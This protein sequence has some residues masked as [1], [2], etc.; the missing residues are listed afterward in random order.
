M[1]EQ[2]KG[3]GVILVVDDAPATV[4]VLERNLSGAGYRVLTAGD[5]EAAL[6]VL[7]VTPV[8]VVVTDLKMPRVTGMEVVRFV[9]ERLP[10][11][12]VMMITGYA[13]I[14]GAVEAVKSG[15]EEYLAKPFTDEELF[16]AVARVFAK[17]NLRRSTRLRT[18]R[19]PLAPEGLL[20]ESPAM[21]TVLE[22][23]SAAVRSPAPLLLTGE[24]GTGKTLAAR[25]VHFA[26]PTRRGPLVSVNCAGTPPERLAS[27]L[28]AQ[29]AN[30][31]ARGLLD[32]ARG[33]TLLLEEVSFLPAAIQEGILET[34]AAIQISEPGPAPVIR[35]IGTSRLGL[36]E[37]PASGSP[38]QSL[39]AGFEARRVELPPLRQRDGDVLLLARHLTSRFSAER[40]W[41]PPALQAEAREVLPAYRWPGNVRELEL[42]LERAVS[43]A[44]EHGEISAAILGALIS[45]REAPAADPLRPLSEVEA[46]HVQQVVAA[47]QGNKTRAAQVLGIDRKTLREKLRSLIPS[48]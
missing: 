27:E 24:T 22:V 34:L 4:E 35:L 46:E 2:P 16:G 45:T 20:G 29:P 42:V 23:L 12:E 3:D 37:L 48:D 36:A 40:G 38:R 39:T 30:V 25:T 10:D 28:F 8:D 21:A 11:T 15:A 9:R 47:C 26:D 14:E 6:A 32:A 33:G 44:G 5:A 43:R 18:V 1:L 41:T 7:A 17:L 31:T 13:T 19:T